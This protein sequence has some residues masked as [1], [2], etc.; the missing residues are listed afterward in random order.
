[1]LCICQETVTG[2]T[3][4]GRKEY[5]KADQG[6]KDKWEFLNFA[7]AWTPG[8]MVLSLEGN[9]GSVKDDVFFSHV[10]R[11]EAWFVSFV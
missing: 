5:L 7:D 9:E 11:M 1:M 10:S 3:L 6:D 2:C 4:N 8:E